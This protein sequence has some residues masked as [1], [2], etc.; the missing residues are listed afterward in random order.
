MFK[1]FI[2]KKRKFNQIHAN[3]LLFFPFLSIPEVQAT[4][5]MYI[6]IIAMLVALQSF[7]QVT[8]TDTTTIEATIHTTTASATQQTDSDKQTHL[9]S[10]SFTNNDIKQQTHA[11][12]AIESSTSSSSSSP[13][14]SVTMD[15]D[16]KIKVEQNLLSLFGRSKRPKPIDRSKVVIPESLKLLYADIMGEELRES[17]NLPKPGLHTKSA[18]TV[19]SFTHEGMYRC[20]LFRYKNDNF[21]IKS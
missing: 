16:T 3:S 9:D 17:V 10:N 20:I 18:N 6:Y 5:Q 14:P 7:V 15:H 11:D 8:G 13:S 21:R 4:M 12:D 2:K 19:R 1:I